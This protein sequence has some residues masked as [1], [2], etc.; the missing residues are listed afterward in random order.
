MLAAVVDRA[1][2]EFEIRTT[3]P[4]TVKRAAR[5]AEKFL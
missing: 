4:K 2:R 1:L 5:L 3:S